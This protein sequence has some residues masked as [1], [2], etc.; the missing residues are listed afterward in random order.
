MIRKL[1]LPGEIV[2]VC[3]MGTGS[4]TKGFFAGALAFQIF[5]MRNEWFLFFN[6]NALYRKSIIAPDCQQ[7][8][9]YKQE[10]EIHKAARKKIHGQACIEETLTEGSMANTT[11]TSC[12]LV[13][14]KS[15]CGHV[16]TTFWQHPMRST[17]LEDASVADKEP[18]FS[19][20]ENSRVTR[21]RKNGCAWNGRG[22]HADLTQFHEQLDVCRWREST[23]I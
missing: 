3:C 1:F 21:K 10:R 15:N 20:F 12:R 19:K 11:W 18:L 7:C 13:C 17:V 4:T 9:R 6:V 14:P 22:K 23:Y 5:R 8:F 2:L 16:V